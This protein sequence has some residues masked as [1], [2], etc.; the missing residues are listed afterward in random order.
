[1]HGNSERRYSSD[2]GGWRSTPVLTRGNP[3]LVMIQVCMLALLHFAISDYLLQPCGHCHR[4]VQSTGGPNSTAVVSLLTIS[5]NTYSGLP[6]P[7]QV[8]ISTCSECGSVTN[9][10]IPPN[11]HV[12]VIPILLRRLY[13]LCPHAVDYYARRCK[14]I[15]NGGVHYPI[16]LAAPKISRRGVTIVLCIGLIAQASGISPTAMHTNRLDGQ[17]RNLHRE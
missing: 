2:A 8:N 12:R 9:A 1:M 14:I 11:L 16:R 10:S 4:Q 15:R 5:Y 6:T 13:N 3:T 17:T 7:Q